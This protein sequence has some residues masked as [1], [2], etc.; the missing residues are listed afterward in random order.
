MPLKDRIQSD[1]E[2]IFINI[3]EFGTIHRWNNKEIECVLDSDIR[4][5]HNRLN[6]VDNSFDI[7]MDEITIYARTADIGY[8]PNAMDQVYFDGRDCR[9]L[10]AHDEMGILEINLRAFDT[11]NIN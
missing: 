5:R 10:S 4:T 3:D 6:I 11:R 2:R 1:N 8:L 9:V 7:V